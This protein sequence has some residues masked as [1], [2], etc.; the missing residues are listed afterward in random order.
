MASRISRRG[1]FRLKRGGENGGNVGGNGDR[2]IFKG[3]NH[4]TDGESNSAELS[5]SH[6]AAGRQSQCGFCEWWGLRVFLAWVYSWFK[7]RAVWPVIAI[8]GW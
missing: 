4:A 8:Y 1:S 7:P 2:F 3:V 6:C 5:S